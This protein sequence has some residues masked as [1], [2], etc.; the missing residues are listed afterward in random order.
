MTYLFAC[1]SLDLDT[2]MRQVAVAD[3]DLE[4]GPAVQPIP[5]DP[6]HERL[7]L[8]QRSAS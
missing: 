6:R 5:S 7:P 4:P 1:R 8:S 2:E 3:R